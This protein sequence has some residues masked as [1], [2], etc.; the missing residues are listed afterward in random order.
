MA[1]KAALEALIA[2]GS[3]AILATIGAD[4][5]PQ[6]S[7]MLYDWDGTAEEVLMTTTETRVKTR[8]LRRDR[9]CSLHVSGG[10]FWS[11]A[12]ATG[13]AEV[14]DHAISPGDEI[15]RRLLPLYTVLMG[16]PED[17]DAF[18]EQMVEEQRLLIRFRY[19]RVHGV[20]VEK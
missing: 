17:E 12:V 11:Y 15:C 5:T 8:N 2:E 9:R 13:E 19:S 14:S 16:A 3:Q 6:L 18:F 1:D 7:N 20:I 10:S 4:G